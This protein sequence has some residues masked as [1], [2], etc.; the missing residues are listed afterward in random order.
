MSAKKYLAL[1]RAGP[2]SLHPHAVERLAQQNFDYALS[3]F[4][5]DDPPAQ[6]A[7]FVHRQKGAKWPGLTETLLAHWADIAPYEFVWLP[8]DDLLCVPETVSRMFAICADLQLELAQPALTSDSYY[9]HPITMQHKLFQLRF[10]NFVEIMAPVL[11][12]RML[13]KVVPTLEANISGFGLDSL[14]P[15][16]TSMGR[17]AILDDTPVKHT[18]PVGGPNYVFNKQAGISP[19]VEDWLVAANHF[20]EQEFDV[21]INFGGL[22]QTGDPIVLGSHP[23]QIN[24]MLKVLID[25]ICAI[26]ISAVQFTRYL[27][28][29]L[30]Y[31]RGG[32]G[33]ARYP[34][35]MVRIALDRALAGTGISFPAPPTA[36]AAQP[37][38]GDSFAADNDRVR[39]GATA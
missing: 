6:G 34:R 21:Q 13:K 24:D 27:A 35:E 5:D 37:G 36:T 32:E 12:A 18:R 22:L 14:W 38:A 9:T 1:F 16:L 28:V 23:Q 17:V 11:S 2:K 25:S 39:E 4:G 7:V 19:G 20:I 30:S 26:K 29:H 33:H 8:D 15:R 3:Y 10:T 31:A